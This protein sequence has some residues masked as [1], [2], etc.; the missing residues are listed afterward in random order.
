MSTYEEIKLGLR[1]ASK[2]IDENDPSL[3]NFAQKTPSD[4]NI[5]FA[6]YCSRVGMNALFSFKKVSFG[7]NVLFLDILSLGTNDSLL[8]NVL[9][10]H[11]YAGPSCRG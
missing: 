9:L 6:L 5:Y 8:F 10:N 11:F 1:P 4:E 7:N 2:N 3:S